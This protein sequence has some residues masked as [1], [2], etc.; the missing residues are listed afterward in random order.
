MDEIPSFKCLRHLTFLDAKLDR[1]PDHETVQGAPIH[2]EWDDIFGYLK[3]L[4]PLIVYAR[5]T[6][7]NCWE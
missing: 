4:C 5:F 6:P 3:A 2:A 1:V 7:S